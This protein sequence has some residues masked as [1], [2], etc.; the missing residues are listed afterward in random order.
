MSNSKDAVRLGIIGCGRGTVVHHLPAL[1]RVPEIKVVAIADLDAARLKKTADRFDIPQRFED[2]RTMISEASIEAAAIVTPTASH[3]EIGTAVLRAGKHLFMEKPLALTLEECDRLIAEA[4]RASC[5]ALVGM[6]NRWHRLILQARNLIRSGTL[7]EPNG[8]HSTYT[9]RHPVES[10][11]AWHKDRN[12]GGGVLFNDGVHHFDLWRFLLDTEVKEIFT[13]SKSSQY[14]DDDTCA[15]SAS[16]DNGMVAGALF[17]FS[18]NPDSELEVF[19][20]A[21]KLWISLYRFDGLRF[22]ASTSYP[23]SI[24]TRL[25]MMANT[26]GAI[27]RALTAFRSGGYF[28]ATYEMLWR[29][30]AECIRKNRSP[31]CTLED[32]RRALE[33]TLAALRSGQTHAPVSIP[34]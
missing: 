27:P 2:Y 23:G 1:A 29:H 8:I 7:G 19:G 16:L 33:I 34:H 6:N 31:M 32:G 26:L 21:G 11:P 28:D 15:V 22:S 18:T 20:E 25:N 30:F 9:H 3:L 17:S 13:H 12:I 4:G 10:A 5:K 14:L 24:K